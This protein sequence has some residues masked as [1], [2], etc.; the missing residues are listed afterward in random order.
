MTSPLICLGAGMLAIL[1]LR[2]YPRSGGRALLASL[3]S[4]AGLVLVLAF[5]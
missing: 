4:A 3:A 2:R 1:V 5:C